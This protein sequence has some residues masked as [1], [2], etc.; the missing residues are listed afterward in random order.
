MNNIN[1]KVA[2]YIK[3]LRF[4][5]RDAGTKMLVIKNGKQVFG[6]TQLRMRTVTFSSPKWGDDTLQ[7]RFTAK[8]SRVHVTG[9]HTKD[10]ISDEKA[11]NS[12]VRFL[13]SYQRAKDMITWLKAVKAVK[14]A[15]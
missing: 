14:A 2:D 1:V 12:V 6:K 10:Y 4:P 9:K 15:E 5:I 11:I 8:S 13:D 3:T 7:F